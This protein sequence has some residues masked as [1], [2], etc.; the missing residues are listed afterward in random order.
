[1]SRPRWS[2]LLLSSW[3]AL[4][5]SAPA[6]AQQRGIH[7]G[8]PMPQMP[9]HNR[10]EQPP[11]PGPPSAR[12]AARGAPPFEASMV[13]PRPTASDCGRALSL[14][15]GDQVLAV[16]P[17]E[18]DGRVQCRVKVMDADGMVRVKMLSPEF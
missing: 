17:M 9:G 6:W 11:L 5:V 4:A 12:E 10:M 1:M 7:G 14:A 16:Q 3:M 18:F 15:P 2:L 8:W 13:R